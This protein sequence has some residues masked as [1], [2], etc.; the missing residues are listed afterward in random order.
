[1]I[2]EMVIQSGAKMYVA[3]AERIRDGIL[4]ME[5]S[6]EQFEQ[7]GMAVFEAL[8]RVLVEPFT[9]AGLQEEMVEAIG[10]E[11]R[12]REIEEIAGRN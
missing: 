10:E 6:Q 5:L 11:I 2:N 1:M 12:R 9:R 7:A 8:D 4:K 3:L